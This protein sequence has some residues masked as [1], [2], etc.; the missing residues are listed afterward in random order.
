MKI[1]LTPVRHN[2]LELYWPVVPVVIEGV[3]GIPIL[4]VDVLIDTGSHITHF[5]GGKPVEYTGDTIEGIGK[6]VESKKANVKPANLKLTI[7]QD[8]QQFVWRTRAWISEDEIPVFGY[9]G[10]FEYFTVTIDSEAKEV[11]IEP[12]TNFPG[13]NPKVWSNRNSKL[14][15]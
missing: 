6:G 10:F 3:E 4:E 8:A 1:P 7:R 13:E 15:L 9:V 11:I 5:P 14:G 12:N 2:K